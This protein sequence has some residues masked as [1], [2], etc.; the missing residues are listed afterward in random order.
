MAKDASHTFSKASA[1]LVRQMEIFHMILGQLWA[2]LWQLCRPFD[3]FKWPSKS[4]MAKFDHK[5][6]HN[7]KVT[8]GHKFTLRML[9]H[10]YSSD[11]T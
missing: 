9:S 2:K 1:I 5:N 4:K 10:E 11:L 8:F 6:G 3:G 7:S